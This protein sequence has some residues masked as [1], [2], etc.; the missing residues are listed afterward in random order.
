MPQRNQQIRQQPAQGFTKTVHAGRNLPSNSSHRHRDKKTVANQIVWRSPLGIARIDGNLPPRREQLTPSGRIAGQAELAGK[1]TARS[2]GKV[3][4]QNR[5]IVVRPLRLANILLVKETID[6]FVQQPVATDSHHPCHALQAQ[7][8]GNLLGVS[9]AFRPMHPTWRD[10]RMLGVKFLPHATGAIV[11][12]LWI[13]D[14]FKFQ[15]G[16]NRNFC[17]MRK[18]PRPWSGSVSKLSP[19]TY[20]R[21][22]GVA[23]TTEDLGKS[24]PQSTNITIDENP[25]VRHTGFRFRSSGLDIVHLLCL[26]ADLLHHVSKR[27]HLQHALFRC[28]NFLPGI[29]Q[30]G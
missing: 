22:S 27:V 17:S 7:V 25:D 5:R 20:C 6:D 8:A 28:G 24:R 3:P 30:R 14:K 26:A 10:L 29:K 18:H 2:C 15:H 21:L 19:S 13:D 11:A 23:P 12:R 1:V 4:Q 16:S 9:T